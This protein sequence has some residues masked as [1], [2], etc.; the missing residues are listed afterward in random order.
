VNHPKKQPVPAWIAVLV[1]I[2]LISGCNLPMGELEQGESER[3]TQAAAWVALTVQAVQ[4]T[5]AAGQ[6]Q[7][8]P[9]AEPPTKEPAPGPTDTPFPD[10]SATPPP[11]PTASLTPTPDQARVYLSENTNCRTGPGSVYDLLSI[12]YSGDK[13]EA[14][15]QDPT[16]EF[17]YIRNPQ[18]PPSFCWLWGNYATPEGDTAS[19]PVFTPPP[20]PTPTPTVPALSYQFS[21]KGMYGPCPSGHF[22]LMY[23]AKNTGTA[24]FESY[25]WIGKDLTAGKTSSGWNNSFY[26]LSTCGKTEEQMDLAPGESGYLAVSLNFNPSGHTVSTEFT[27]CTQDGLS[28]DCL[29]KAKKH[30]P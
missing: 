21:Y 20:T 27:L 11:T 25:G 9:T 6:D 28:G 29:T 17:W 4:Q 12:L 26:D 22:H 15:A 10:A 23:L 18:A 1:L 13:S 3:Q 24:V 14:V 7:P 2:L 30:T 8:A 5:E 16:G 19:L